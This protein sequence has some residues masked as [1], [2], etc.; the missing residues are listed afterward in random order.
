MTAKEKP[1]LP[2]IRQ[3]KGMAQFICQ[4]LKNAGIDF[5]VTLPDSWLKEVNAL[6]EADPEIKYVTVTREEE[7]IGVAAGATLGGKAVAITM[8]GTGLGNSITALGGMHLA[9]YLPLLILA[10]YRSAIGERFSFASRYCARMNLVLEALG[11][12]YYV[13]RDAREA[14][15]LIADCQATAVAQRTPVAVLIS[16]SVLWEEE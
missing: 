2:A 4:G 14:P 15:Q 1:G 11:I 8:E 10:S 9:R 5:V 12:P 7:G 6:I 3:S 16:G 13:L